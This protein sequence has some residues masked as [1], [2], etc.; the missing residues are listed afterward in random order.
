LYTNYKTIDHCNNSS[1]WGGG[2]SFD[3]FVYA[4][5]SITTGGEKDLAKLKE[6]SKNRKQGA[7]ISSN[8]I[9]FGNRSMV[10]INGVFKCFDK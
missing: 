5:W 9:G 1:G 8:S 6:M 2:K 7:Y 10:G 4:E 3:Y